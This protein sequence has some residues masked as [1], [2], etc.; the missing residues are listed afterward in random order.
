[1]AEDSNFSCDNPLDHKKSDIISRIAVFG[2]AGMN[3]PPPILH[4]FRTD[5]S[6]EFR[7]NFDGLNCLTHLTHFN[8]FRRVTL[9]KEIGTM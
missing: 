2:F 3:K 9:P 4:T 6:S 8:T 7:S 1:M 5:N